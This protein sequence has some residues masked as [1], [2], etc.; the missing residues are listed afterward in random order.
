MQIHEY[1]YDQD[2]RSLYV[3]FSTKQD[4]DKY[5]RRVDII[6]SDIEYYSTT[7]ITEQDMEDID[8]DF[9]V[10]FLEQ[11]FKENEYPEEEIL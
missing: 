7:I 9:V 6:F 3:E 5:F 2:K 8:E 1:Y 10:E 11:Y 4:K